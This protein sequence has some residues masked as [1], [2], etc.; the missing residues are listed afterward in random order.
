MKTDI[1]DDPKS[2]KDEKKKE[3]YKRA[4]KNIRVK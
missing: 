2:I 3:A 4:L 1:F